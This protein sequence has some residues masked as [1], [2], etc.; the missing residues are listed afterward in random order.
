MAYSVSITYAAE[1]DIWAA[2]DYISESA[3]ARAEQWFRG[4]VSEIQGLSDMPSLYSYAPE[5][6]DL[7]VPLRHFHYYSHRVIFLIRDETTEV[8]VL[9]VWHSARKAIEIGQLPPV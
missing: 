8:F 3:P 6:D 4:L 9:R 7:S 1:A 2:V 5:A